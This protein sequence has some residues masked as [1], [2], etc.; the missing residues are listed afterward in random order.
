[1]ARAA[2]AGV[3]VH[4]S[5]T[6]SGQVEWIASRW[7]LTRAFGSLSELERWLDTVAGRS[8]AGVQPL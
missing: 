7:A 1:V 2:L 5:Q 6:E 3:T 4:R 8:S